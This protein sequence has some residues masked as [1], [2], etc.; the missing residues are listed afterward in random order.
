[1]SPLRY[2]DEDSSPAAVAAGLLTGAVAGFAV[3]V[4]VAQRLGGLEGLVARFRRGA[5]HLG[6]SVHRR[7]EEHEEQ[8]GEEDDLDTE[9][10]EHVLEAFQNDP[11]LSERAIDIG[12]V[13][14]GMIELAGWVNTEEESEHA[15]TIARGVPH[16]QT[17][18]NRLAIG[19]REQLYA[20]NAQRVDEGDP[21]L[22]E[23]RW[24]GQRVGTGRRRQGTS[25]EPD[26]HADPRPKLES[27]W[28]NE[29]EAMR[30]AAGDTGGAAERRR[31]RKSQRGDRS[32]GA[33]VTPTGVPKGD[34][35]ANPDDAESL[36]DKRDDSDDESRAD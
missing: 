23:T 30:N 4:A 1:M 28:L 25:D 27:R 2:R 26:R 17:V 31:G 32:G 14:E 3:G 12:S 34:H 6:E 10:E 13:G 33:P 9:L 8:Y 24:E 11:V 20:S 19:E 36:G 7:F 35:V 15:V 29:E 16:V 5:A 22:T 21:A 18:V